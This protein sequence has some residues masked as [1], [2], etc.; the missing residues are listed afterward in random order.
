MDDEKAKTE[1]FDT[2]AAFLNDVQLGHIAEAVRLE[3]SDAQVSRDIVG[4]TRQLAWKCNALVYSLER[5]QH[6]KICSG[7]KSEPLGSDPTHTAS[8]GAI[9]AWSHI[10]TPLPGETMH[11]LQQLI[12]AKETVLVGVDTSVL[13]GYMATVAQEGNCWI[14][15]LRITEDTPFSL[16]SILNEI[17]YHKRIVSGSQIGQYH[18]MVELE[19]MQKLIVIVKRVEGKT[20]RGCCGV[21]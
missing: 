21:Q 15:N 11:T 4:Q 8:V 9:P 10:T 20:E 14:G 6:D 5:S 12:A 2:L 13:D 16:R 17:S 1:L 7:D 19:N 18:Q 3:A